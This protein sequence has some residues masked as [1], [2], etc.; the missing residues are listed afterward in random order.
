[1]KI[2]WI[3]TPAAGCNPLTT[4]L[5]EGTNGEGK[6]KLR[7]G[8]YA[9]SDF[10]C[11]LCFAMFLSSSDLAGADECDPTKILIQ[12]SHDKQVIDKQTLDTSS[13]KTKTQ[14]DQVSSS[15]SYLG[16]IT[17]SVNGAFAD[18]L[19]ETF[20]LKS[21]HDYSFAEAYLSLS[22][23]ARQAYQACL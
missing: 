12:D 2:I 7:G 18:A 14:N 3:G 16:I 13:S 22:D 19:A 9:E 15:G 5:P 20:N 6:N 21:T 23:N 10:R 11:F 4:A 8:N 17:G 1:V